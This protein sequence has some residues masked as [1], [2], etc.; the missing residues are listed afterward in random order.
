MSEIIDYAIST[1]DWAIP[2]WLTE[3]FEEP[4]AYK[5]I[6]DETFQQL[7]RRSRQLIED[8]QK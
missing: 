8:S 5:E 1:G 2:E 3:D 6:S 4:K 7:C